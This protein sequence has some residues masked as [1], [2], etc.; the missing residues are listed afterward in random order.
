LN[1]GWDTQLKLD[2]A[3]HYD[4][5]LESVTPADVAALARKYL[6]DARMIKISA[7]T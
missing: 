1:A 5:A 7:G 6:T 4:Q 2:R 3:R